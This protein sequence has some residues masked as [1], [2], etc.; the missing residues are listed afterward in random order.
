MLYA[1]PDH[2]VIE[3]FLPAIRQN[4]LPHRKAAQRIRERPGVIPVAVNP[5]NGGSVYFADIGDAPLREWKFIYT[6]QR[7]ATEN[8]IDEAFCTDHSILEREDLSS[9]GLSP[10][11]LIFHVSRC[12]STLFAKALARSPTNL[13]INQGGPLQSGFWSVISS[14]WQHRPTVNERNIRMLRN[15]VRLM[16][17][18]RRPGQRRCYIKFI[19]WNVI[20]MDLIR[21]AF[22]DAAAVYL[23]RDPAEVIAT[24]LEETTAVLGAKGAPLAGYL[25][26]LPPDQTA[27]ISDVEYLARCYAHYFDLVE[28]QAARFDVRLIDYRHLKE[29][30]RFPD[31]LNRGLG[32][33]PPADE[34][35]RMR[36]QYRYDSKDDSDTIVFSGDGDHPAKQLARMDRQLIRNICE[37][38][39]SRL[40]RSAQNL[41]P[42]DERFTRVDPATSTHAF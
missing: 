17:R 27:G 15:L 6:I 13:V 40:N 22:P 38:P 16:A 35:E 7:L 30:E 39:L 31:V 37:Q 34:L 2:Q 25:T 33:I 20:C 9:D 14:R 28:R 42:A 1:L 3:R 18:Q 4:H 11:G 19:S 21:A 41:Y 29:R 10:D 32:L 36:E 12:G 5:E 8:R 23:Y 24:V 26:G